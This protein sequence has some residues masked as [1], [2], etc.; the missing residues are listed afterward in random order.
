MEYSMKKLIVWLAKVFNVNIEVE[1]VVIKEVTKIEKEYVT[2]GVI[3]GDVT[4]KGNLLING[5]LSVSG[6]VT[7]KSI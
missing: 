5:K 3:E 6:D 1:K 7:I 4:I 2:E